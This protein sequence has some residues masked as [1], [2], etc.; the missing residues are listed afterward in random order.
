MIGLVIGTLDTFEGGD[1]RLTPIG[2]V[3]LEGEGL[4][5]GISF[6]IYCGVSLGMT[7]LS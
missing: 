1:T 5:R 2:L 4:G 6:L 7:S 3:S